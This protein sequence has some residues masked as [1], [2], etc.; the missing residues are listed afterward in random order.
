M[1]EF[2]PLLF[3]KKKRKKRASTVEVRQKL[4]KKVCG[5]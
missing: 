2:F 5:D 3:K 4:K 1:E